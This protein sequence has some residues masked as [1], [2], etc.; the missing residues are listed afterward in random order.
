MIVVCPSCAAYYGVDRE[1]FGLYARVV[2]CSACGH[3]WEAIPGDYEPADLK[4]TG[5]LR[6]DRLD[7]G[8]VAAGLFDGAPTR[9]D[10][11][12]TSY[13]QGLGVPTEATQRPADESEEGSWQNTTPD[14]GLRP[15][16]LQS[17]AGGERISE[18]D[19]GP[20]EAIAFSESENETLLT[21]EAAIAAEDRPPPPAAV[22]DPAPPPSRHRLFMAAGAA[23]ALLVCLVV[24]IAAE[25]PITRAWPGAAAVYSLFGLAPAPPGAGLDIRDVSSSREWSGSEDVLIVA[26]TVANV[27]AGP[28]E[29][30]PLR[31]TLFDADRSEVQAV[32]VQPVKAT[33]LEGESVPFVARIPHPAMAARRVVVSFQPPSAGHS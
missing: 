14:A 16:D 12:D 4:R 33:L 29:L 22:D 7:E 26:G 9:E 8:P 10:A 23:A 24:L 6:A 20:Q 3:E 1:A 15:D 17:D 21:S 2:R 19:P 11:S 13:D 32:V 30:P 5:E 25:R 27:A 31:V 18:Q 28:R